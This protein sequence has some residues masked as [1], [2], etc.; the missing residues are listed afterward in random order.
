MTRLS[1]EELGWRPAD[2]QP[3]DGTTRVTVADEAVELRWPRPVV[4][5]PAQL[6][7]IAGWRTIP[8]GPLSE[9]AGDEAGLRAGYH[10]DL[11]DSTW[12]AASRINEVTFGFPT[13]EGES[14]GGYLWYRTR[15]ARPTAGARSPSR[16]ARRWSA[17]GSPGASSPTAWRRPRRRSPVAW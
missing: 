6:A 3:G 1:I 7:H 4:A 5:E 13:W 10:A 9:A 14:Y 2:H 16:S 11:D 8:G 15:A 17:G 12:Y